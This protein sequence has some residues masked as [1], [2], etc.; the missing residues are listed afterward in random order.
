MT[1]VKRQA[2]SLALSSL[3]KVKEHSRRYGDG[4]KLR[5]GIRNVMEAKNTVQQVAE[6]K[7]CTHS[8]S[9]LL[10]GKG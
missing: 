7:A 6:S 9:W 10:E 8:S 2:V 4:S 3:R 1:G 5:A